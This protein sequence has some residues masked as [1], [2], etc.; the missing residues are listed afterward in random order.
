LL[1]ARGAVALSANTAGVMN[2]FVTAAN[3]VNRQLNQ[4][5]MS[6]RRFNIPL[7]SCAEAEAKAKGVKS[8]LASAL[9]FDIVTCEQLL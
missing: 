2:L 5:V 8:I 6:I 3:R 9:A 1:A 7:K 4:R